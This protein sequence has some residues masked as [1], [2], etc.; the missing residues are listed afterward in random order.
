MR[1]SGL[2]C[3]IPFA[4]LAFLGC[5]N[6][7]GPKPS[8]TA[9]ESPSPG[10]SPPTDGEHDPLAGS[11]F[12]KDD[13]FEIYAAEAAG[14]EKKTAAYKRHRLLDASGQPVTAR[15]EAYERALKTYATQ[16]REGWAKFVESLPE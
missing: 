10:E 4:G 9:S 12:S 2:L 8:P 7:D 1:S 13:L 16:D 14:G 11:V 15:E 6:G 5:P 3:L